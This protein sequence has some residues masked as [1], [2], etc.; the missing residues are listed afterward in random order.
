MAGAINVTRP[1]PLLLTVL[2][3]ATALGP[4]A[5]QIFLPALPAIQ[6]HYEVSAATAQLAFS[7]SAFSIAIATLFYGPL[8]DRFGRRPALLGGIIIYLLGS[9]ICAIAPSMSILIVGRI[10][11][12]AGGCA[13]IVVSRAIIR[14]LYRPEEAAAALAY[15]T[16]A[17]VIA[18]MLA[19]AI[20]GFA[21]ETIDW[22]SVFWIGAIIGA[23]VLTV[24]FRKLDETA[25][26]TTA[27]RGTLAMFRDIGMLVRSPVFI[28][29]S[30]HGAFSMAVFF[31]FLAAAPYLMIT[32]LERPTSEYGLLFIFISA[33][34]MAGNYTT[35]RV[36]RHFG[37]NRMIIF[38]TIGA[39]IASCCMLALVLVGFFNPLVIFMP[40]A[41]AGFFQGLTM[42]NSQAAVVSVNPELAGSASG[43]AGFTQM[44]TA[45][46]TAQIIGSIQNGTPYPLAFGM[47]VCAVLSLIAAIMAVRAC[48]KTG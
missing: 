36:T 2:I 4:F 10:V 18:P 29:Y 34:F 22:R 28:G 12:A 1:S 44:G 9:L 7:L 25:P 48:K 16:M 45:A 40:M 42:A 14:D 32:V 3:M 46:V 26:S 33:T 41:F 13:G 20:G 19:P 47:A 11:Q 21:I 8:S 37:L 17:M 6:N 35:A 23:A 27:N 39:L 30:L 24:T 5:M 31:S 43:I 38:G 15:I